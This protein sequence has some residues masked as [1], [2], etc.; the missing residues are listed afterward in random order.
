MQYI[1][2]KHLHSYLIIYLTIKNNLYTEGYIKKM[3]ILL[4]IYKITST[5]ESVNK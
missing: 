3:H 5:N 2:H 1:K 4:Y